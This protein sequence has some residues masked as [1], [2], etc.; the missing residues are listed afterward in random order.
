MST[1]EAPLLEQLAANSAPYRDPLTVLDWRA[2]S[3]DRFWLPAEAIS[4]NGLAEFDALSESAQM[5]LSQYELLGFA[6]AGVALE[7]IFLELT[8]RRLRRTEPSAEYAYLLHEMREE[9]G[10]SLMFLKLA[11]ASGL[12]VPDWRKALPAFARPLSRML[13]SEA[14]YWFMMV[15]A[16]DVPDKLNRFVRR[17]SGPDVCPL[18]R[19][20]ITLHMVDEARHL[21]YAR[22][23]LELSMA[24]RVR[25]AVRAFPGLFN[26]LFNR[27]VRAYFW[28]RAE[29]YERAGL[30]DGVAWR[31]LARRNPHRREFVL[32]LLAPTM[33]LL[34]GHGINVR[35]R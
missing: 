5:R 33:R 9:A 19:Q 14:L 29:V 8:A 1:P 23:R 4:L 17:Q 6:Q 10:H 20:M 28:P 11:A 34:S 3:L 18:V 32:R 2:L 30:G 21:A 26:L 35:L 31:R 15:V 7:R 27:F 12:D 13:P 25:V 22:R 16:E 24:G